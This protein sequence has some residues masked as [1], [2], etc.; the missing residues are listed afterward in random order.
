VI[1]TNLKGA[2]LMTKYAARGM[3]KRRWGASSTLGA[4]WG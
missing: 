2:F 3:I 1:D 4:W